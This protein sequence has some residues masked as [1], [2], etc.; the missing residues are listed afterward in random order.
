MDESGERNGMLPY[1]KGYKMAVYV[2]AAI[3]PFVVLYAW[4]ALAGRNMFSTLEGMVALVVVFFACLLGLSR[5]LGNKADQKA[6]ALVS[7]YNDACDPPAFLEQGEPLAQV[8][9]PPYTEAGSWFLS[10]YAL[11]LDDV[12]RTS[13]A[14]AIGTAMVEGAKHAPNPVVRAGLLVNMEPVVV[15][16]F[17]PEAAL[18]VID[19]AEAALTQAGAQLDDRENFLSWERAIL[20]ARR[21]GNDE[22][23]LG[24]FSQIYM[25]ASYLPRMRVQAAEEVAAILRRR[26]DAAGERAALT[27]VVEHGNRLPAVRA[28]RERLA[29]LG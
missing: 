18:G 17:G 12:G 3:A 14:A 16:L 19:E 28:A 23:L 9:E 13:E 5:V 1:F 4:S 22:E 25:S 7:L 11:A 20:Q 2:V 24:R 21:D 6:D 8:I 27:F 15:R 26:G 29:E 10:F